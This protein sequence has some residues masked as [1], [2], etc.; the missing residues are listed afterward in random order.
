M[1][2]SESE[3]CEIYTACLL[4]LFSLICFPKESFSC[5]KA[6]IVEM[7]GEKYTFLEILCNAVQEK[8]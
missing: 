8:D 4:M 3:V 2:R 6:L 5:N 1:K 7:I